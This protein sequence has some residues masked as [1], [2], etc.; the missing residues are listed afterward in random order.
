MKPALALLALLAASPASAA[1]PAQEAFFAR[2]SA[3]C[4]KSFSGRLATS[5]PADAAFAGQP[6]VMKVASCTADEIRIPF[7]VGE[8]RSRTWI[9]TRTAEGL[10][11]KHDHRHADGS[12]DAVSRYGGDTTSAGTDAR[13]AFPVDAFS[14]E[15][16]A[17][18][19]RAAS[20]TNV[21]AME[22]EPSRLFAYEL[23]RPNR[24]FRVEFD[25]G[26]PLP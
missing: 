4:G 14:K 15:L 25:L 6:L 1:A 10:R 5:D 7:S 26:K 9:V 19:N 3:L 12:E 18:E 24:H 22:V 21:W 17:R 11:L 2:L 16:F 8:D 20:L 13:Q 23:R